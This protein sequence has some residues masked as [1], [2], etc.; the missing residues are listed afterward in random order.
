[1]SDNYLWDRTRTPDPEL[2]R[3]EQQLGKYK[4]QPAPRKRSFPVWI[5]LALAASIAA[6]TIWQLRS[7]PLSNWTIADQPIALNKT[8]HIDRETLLHVASIGRLRFAPGA[9]FKVTRSE[10]GH[11][12]MD[13]L[14][15]KFESLIIA[16]PHVFQVNTLPAK[17]DDLGCAYEV[18][19][20]QAGSGRVAVTSGW[21]HVNAKGEESL[22]R[23]G[24]EVALAKGKPPSIPRRVEQH[25]DNDPLTLLH[26]LWRAPTP[27]DRAKAFDQ[28]ASQFPP[29]PGVTRQRALNGDRSIVK[30]YWPVLDLGPNIS[31]P[32]VFLD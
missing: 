27:L 1:M 29:P 32:S 30:D 8:I 13:L 4:F 14:E 10:P 11:Q 21:L 6:L 18:S 3:L 19:V 20:N 7:Q 15:G 17:L 9:K 24:Y 2:V 26:Q 23:Q 22:V 28:L 31:L 25:D 12:H 5:P 16:A